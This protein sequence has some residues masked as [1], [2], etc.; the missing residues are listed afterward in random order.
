MKKRKFSWNDTGIKNKAFLQVGLL[1]AVVVLGSIAIFALIFQKSAIKEQAQYTQKRLQNISVHLDTYINEVAAI[2]NETNYDYYLQNYLMQVKEGEGS[3]ITMK[4]GGNIQNYEMGTKIFSYAMNN[5]TDVSSI[6]VFGKKE[7]LLYKSLYSY[8]NVAVNYQTYPWYQKALDNPT[9]TVVTGPQSHEFLS[10][11]T[12]KTLSLSRVIRNCESGS[13]LG[14]ILIDINLNQIAEICSS[15]YSSGESAF[16]ILDQEGRLVYAQQDGEEILDFHNQNTL[17]EVGGHVKGDA[18][19]EKMIS[20]RGGRYQ[21]STNYMEETDWKLVSLTP[22]ST[23]L[24]R[25]NTTIRFIMISVIVLI[26]M[27]LLALNSILSKVI[28]PI[29]VLKNKMDAAQSDNLKVRA[30]VT[31]RDEVGMLAQSYNKMMERIETLMNQVVVEQESKRKFELQALQAQ[32]N[33]HFL[34]NTLDA[35]I[36]MAETKDEKVVAM[37]EAL[38]RLFRIAL[39]KGNECIT[40]ENEL[41]HVRNYLIIQNMRYQN[42]FDYRLTVD[43]EV[44]KCRTIKLIIQPIVENSIYHGIKMKKIKGHIT[45]H[46]YTDGGK[47]WIEVSDDG[48]GMAPEICDTILESD[49]KRGHTTGSGVGVRNVNARIK[50]YFGDDYG[51]RFESEEGVGTKATICIPYLLTTGGGLS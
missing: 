48:A 5:R 33:P 20:L 10:G 31:S 11:N 24:K 41:E 12:E 23:I 30:E 16:G 47:V 36:W 51:L 40:L 17:D 21:L 3:S 44:K 45:I 32:I 13:F 14:V 18:I 4:K 35:I 27:V 50:L 46:A 19:A 2:A 26:V 6:L 8:R 28:K 38:A 34:Y 49:V 22:E 43:E 39:N 7:V 9:K 29:T 25:V 15:S 37:T 42:K 1:V